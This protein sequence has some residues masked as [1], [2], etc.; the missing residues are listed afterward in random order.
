MVIHT[1]LYYSQF[2]HLLILSL[3]KCNNISNDGDSLTRKARESSNRLKF[4][5]RRLRLDIKKNVFTERVIEPWNRLSREAVESP[6]LAMFKT[7]SV[8][9]LGT[10]C[11]RGPGNPGLLVGCDPRGH[12][13]PY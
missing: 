3:I 12:Y 7:S 5:K 11:R 8:G 6:Y 1:L 2:H 9:C 13:H 10:R 4:H